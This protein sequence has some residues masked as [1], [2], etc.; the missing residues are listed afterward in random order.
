MQ[1]I[2]YYSVLC[3]PNSASLQDIKIAYR[4]L[5]KKYHPDINHSPDAT[6]K[7]QL[8]NE[9]YLILSDTDARKLY[10]IEWNRYFAPKEDPQKPDQDN[11]TKTGNQHSGQYTNAKSASGNTDYSFQNET[12]KDWVSKARQQANEITAQAIKDTG[13]MIKEAGKGVANGVIKAIFYIVLF[14]SYF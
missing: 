3:I 5:V 10:D 11:T 6:A 13:G 1:F 12:L 4:T 7:M 14:T 9:A 8:L 2:N